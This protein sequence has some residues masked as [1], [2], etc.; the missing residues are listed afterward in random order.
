MT[1]EAV[2]QSLGAMGDPE[3]FLTESYRALLLAHDTH[4]RDQ[5]KRLENALREAIREGRIRVR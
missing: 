1:R 3:W 5:I 2:I 4:Q